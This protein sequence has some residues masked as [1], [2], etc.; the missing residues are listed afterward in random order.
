MSSY[1]NVRAGGVKVGLHMSKASLTSAL[2]RVFSVLIEFANRNSYE[3][4]ILTVQR[5]HEKKFESMV[6]SY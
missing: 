3:A 2:W 6:N 1:A 4:Q 5:D